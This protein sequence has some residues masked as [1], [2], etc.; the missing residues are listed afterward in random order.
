MQQVDGVRVRDARLAV[1]ISHGN[2]VL[3][4]TQGWGRVSARTRPALAAEAALEAAFDHAGGRSLSDELLAEPRLE[5]LTIAPPEAAADAP[6]AGRIGEGY[7]HRLVWTV[8]FRRAP[9]HEAWEALVAADDGSLLA[10]QD[11]NDYLLKQIKG[12]VYPLTNTEAC[13][14]ASQCGAMQ[15]NWPMPFADTNQASPQ[16][17]TNSAG[18][19]DFT[20]GTTALTTL[21]GKYVNIADTCGAIS[22]GMFFGFMNLFGTNGDHDCTAAGFSP[23]N[24]PASRSAFYELNRIA[25]QGRG[26]LPSNAWLKAQ[27]TANVN[28]NQVCNAFWSPGGGTVNFY[29]TGTSTV[30]PFA[31]CGNTGEIAAVFDHEWGHGL[32][33]N[34]AAALKSNSSEAYADIA[35]IYRL[36]A[37]CVGHGFFQAYG[38]DPGCG[39]ASDGLPNT[40]EAIVGAAHCNTNC[41]GVRDADWGLHADNTPDTALGFVCG[42][43]SS[44]SGPCGRQV[45]CAAAPVRQAAWDLVKRDLTSAP[46]SLNS[47]TA[48]IVGT[49]LFYQGS[50]NVG[51][52]HACTCGNPSGGS[53]SGCG[54]TNGYMQWL[55]ADDD[56]GNLSDGTPHMTAL[57]AAFNRHGIACGSPAPVNAGCSGG[58]T[59]APTLT[60]TAGDNAVGLSWTAV[61]GADAYWVFR[62][63]GHAGCNLGKTLIATVSS[64]T[65]YID[66]QVANGRTYYYNVVAKGASSACYGRA[67]TCK[68]ATPA[69]VPDVIAPV[70]NITS[71][72]EDVETAGMSVNITASAYDD[73]GVTKVEFWANNVLKSTDTAAPYLATI[74]LPSLGVYNIVAKGY[75]AA[76]NIG[77][78][79]VR[80]VIRLDACD[81]FHAGDASQ[82]LLCCLETA[83]RAGRQP[84]CP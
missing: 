32:D 47:E 26:W 35:S 12:G 15:S 76:G 67:S 13:P 37:S 5:L 45:H 44:G 79:P 30:S 82:E 69:D 23:G 72:S 29:R 58:P 36:N 6:Y 80:Q 27:L 78:S 62:T 2:V 66:K 52:W 8:S 4:G 9:E 56:N 22:E 84:V 55:A 34:D 68:S 16:Q 21:S 33:Y 71:P 25:E 73:V 7:R 75:D 19:F 24:T 77:V 60:L 46:F 41:A 14:T 1:T 65:K 64:G 49:K 10:F 43:C 81:L 54:A 11:T 38:V 3:M 39:T 57:Y 63:E 42:S 53:S 50:G 40:D 18:L 51:E 70:V 48:L 20:S 74:P 31:T 83:R 17:F 59:S 61:S 28:I